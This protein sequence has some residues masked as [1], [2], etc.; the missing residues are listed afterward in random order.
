[1]WLQIH[2]LFFTNNS[3]GRSRE[4]CAN[5]RHSP[6]SVS[7][8]KGRCLTELLVFEIVFIA[9]CHRCHEDITIEPFRLNE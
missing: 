5:A 2:I 9:V 6:R 8:A 4:F 7:C 1:L 3:V